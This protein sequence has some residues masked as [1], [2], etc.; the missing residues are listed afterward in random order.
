V[1]G[2]TLKTMREQLGLTQDELADVIGVAGKRVVSNIET[3][4]R[5]ASPII[6]AL[7]D[8]L[9]R[10]PEKRSRELQEMLKESLKIYGKYPRRRA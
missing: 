7:M 2:Q 5:N 1:K 6:L 9:C 3:E 4:F 8:V 10:L